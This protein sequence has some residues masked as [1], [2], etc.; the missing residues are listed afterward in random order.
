MATYKPTSW[1]RTRRP[2]H[3]RE[4]VPPAKQAA[5]TVTVVTAAQLVQNLTSTD[6]GRNGYSTENQRYLH[7]LVSQSR[8]GNLKNIMLSG[9]TCSCRGRCSLKC[10]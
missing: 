8:S 7:V 9:A 1:G 10:T 2:K 4:N 3:L 6:E 5:T